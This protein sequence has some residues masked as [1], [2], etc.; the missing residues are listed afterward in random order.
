MAIAVVNPTK[1]ALCTA[2]AQLGA[3]ISV[4]TGDPGTTGASEAQNGSPAYTRMAT[5]WGAA[6][7]GSITGS[8]VTI[9]LPAGTYGWAGLWTAASGGTFL[10][11]VQ[12]PPT[13]LGAQGTLLITPTFTIS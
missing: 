6:A 13:T 8:Q 10:D 12:I 11:K 5:T 9:N 1:N 2:Y 7:N 3:Y 4:H